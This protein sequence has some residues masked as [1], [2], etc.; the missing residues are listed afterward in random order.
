MKDKQERRKSPGFYMSASMEKQ[1]DRSGKSDFLRFFNI[2]GITIQVQADLPF[3]SG[4]FASKFNKFK[5]DKPG[6]DIVLIHHHFSLPKIDKKN[7]G[8]LVYSK[9]PWDIYEKEGYWMYMCYSRFLGKKIVHIV[10][11][12]DPGHTEVG[13]YHAND[14][15]FL[16]GGFQALT[17]M[18]TDQILLA[19]VLADREGCYLH[20]SG[21]IL[22]G[23]G[24]LFA[25]HSEAGKT[26]MI[27]MLQGRSEIL[28]DDRM[29]LR[30]WKDGFRIHGT[31][32]HGDIS[33]VSSVSAPLHGIF[34]LYKSKDNRIDPINER[35]TIIKKILACMI[36]PMVSA[37]WWIKSLSLVEKISWSVP[38]Y[39]LYF[40]KT[41]RI[42]D[43]LM[44]L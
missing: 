30:Y 44:K 40:D 3:S 20:S 42:A 6:D 39:D 1:I 29:I 25:G 15:A 22:D 9:P 23:K 8:R 27:R 4:S 5:V 33:E 36:R 21:V 12:M 35:G 31:W 13:I 28:C 37:D 43:L 24:L 32:S 16:R 2:A 18:P 41:G 11:D 19:R 17:L 26:T 7:K 34:F 14:K 38:C 10:S